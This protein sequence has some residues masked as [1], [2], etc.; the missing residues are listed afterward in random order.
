MAL[1]GTLD[2][3]PAVRPAA[4]LAALAR[5][6]LAMGRAAGAP[7]TADR[8]W[9]LAAELAALMDEAELSEVDLAARLPDAADPEHAAH[10]QET[11][12]FLE[13][14]SRAWP[15][16]LAEQGLM[17]PAARQAA[18]LRA[19]AAAWEA[20]PPEDRVLI[21]GTTGAVPA[22]ARL[23]RSVA[24]LELGAVVLPGLDTEMDEAA[25]EA[26]EASHPQAGMRAL[27]T[28]LGATRGDVRTLPVAGER[29]GE[30]LAP[31]TR[32]GVLATAL[33]PAAAI[34][35]WRTA[36]AAGIAGL[37]RLQAADQQ[38]EAAAIAL[39]LRDALETR[40]RRAALITPDRAL[41]GRVAAEL[42]RFGVVADDS[43]GEKLAD[44]PPAVFLRLLAHAV[45][46]QLAP[47][48][49]LAL[50]K[51]PLAAA[52]LPP[53]ACRDAARALELAALRGPR[54]PPG[55]RGLREA[56][57][58]AS[59]DR[60]EPARA[61]LA[62]VEGCLAP[63]LRIASAAAVAAPAQALASLIEA[64]ER[65]AATG[66]TA[67]GARLW[68]AEEGEALSAHLAGILAVLPGLPD[69]P[70]ERLPALLEAV[71]EGETLRTRRA[72]RGREGSEHPRVFIWGL[73][74][75]RLQSVDLAVLGGLSEGVW[76]PAA[77]PGPWLSRRMRERIGLPSPE[78]R[79]GQAAHDFTALACTAREVVL[80]CPR[81]R[82]GAPA[83]P[84]RW[85]VRLDAFL[86]G[87][88]ARLPAHPAT[89]WTRLLD[90]PAGGPAAAPP[91]RPRPDIRL[92]PRRLSVTEIET[93][94]RDPYAIHA[95]HILRLRPLDPLDES[96]DAA[97]Y[98]A[99]AHR[100]LHRFLREHGAAWPADAEAKLGEAM[101][102][103][104]AEAR[105]REALL[106]WWMPRF[107][108][109]AGWV[110]A[111]ETDRRCESAPEA[112]V[113]EH[114]GEWRLARP[115]GEFVL[116][117][118][119]DRI[120]R[121]PD[122]RLTII[123]YK[124]GAP[125]GQGQVDAGFAPQLPLEAAMAEAGAFGGQL[126]AA[127]AELA[128]WHITGGFQPG[129]AIPLFKQGPRGARGRRGARPE[130]ADR[131]DRRV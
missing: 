3:P 48:P 85:L 94:L 106:A 15:A 7:R 128:Y 54:P 22:V 75:A 6:V 58:R 24:R 81:R 121:R 111:H 25:W 86:T 20:A 102:A 53:A 96:A 32:S 21:A 17:N 125:P 130:Q 126:E 100:G 42:L 66:D 91:P 31:G 34:A 79:V 72:L 89:G 98:G 117:G 113:T 14:V 120:E 41:A 40:G 104:L 82:D 131:A 83:V 109:I 116:R 1:A 123:D 93:W 5:L 103:E 92:R 52:G 127:A 44:T 61:F 122:G 84:S 27:L 51:H 49:L 78:A 59:A 101:R 28:S 118:R 76:P 77:D 19:Q 87:Q 114:P 12:T 95:R 39:I 73:L 99:L 30:R 2:L 10:W 119:A 112:L 80:S 38:E 97:R 9:P 71:L 13:I 124:T 70:I 110:A 63:A 69:Q 64:G 60:R 65:L 88:G 29:R 90:Q 23:L 16:W 108:R 56:I 68:A 18:L 37:H 74:E 67:G 62:R 129:K 11:L 47:V 107:G 8:A 105:L 50:L 45:A 43:A 46:G 26:I 35:S 36:P 33:L 115:G 55:L 4:R 57:D